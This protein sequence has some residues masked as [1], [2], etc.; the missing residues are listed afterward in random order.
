MRS[1]AVL[2]PT[3]G[4][5]FLLKYWLENYDKYWRTEADHL[6]IHLNTPIEKEVVKYEI[7]LFEKYG[8]NYKYVDHQIEHGDAINELLDWVQEE[9]LMLVEDDAYIFTRG[10]VNAC[11]S[12]LESG[13]YDLVGSKRGSCSF[14]ILETAKQ[15]WGLDYTG[16]GDQGCNFWPCY[17]FTK[18]ETLKKTDRRFGARAWKRGELVEPLNH[19]IENEEVAN[20]DTFVNTS[21][22]LRAMG[23]KILCIPQYHGSPDDLKHYESKENLW[24]GQS[25]WTHVGSLSSGVGGVLVN[26]FGVSLARRKI[27]LERKEFNLPNAGVD[28]WARRLQWWKTFYDNS[29]DSIP[30]FKEEYIK[31]IKRLQRKAGVNDKLIIKRQ[32][33]YRELGL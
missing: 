18:T 10:T 32:K 33:I 19:I 13:E 5:P 26:D 21:L 8:V 16:Y 22:Q 9:Y 7:G 14:E 3:P 31:S 30:E 20:G 12:S 24:D 28:E 27:D 2:L 23:L 15:K 11:F 6:Y 29:D 25:T 17:L 4:D 1:R